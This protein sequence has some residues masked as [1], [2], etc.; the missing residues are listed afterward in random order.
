VDLFSVYPELRDSRLSVL[1]DR[2][3]RLISISGFV[4][5][6]TAFYL[7][8]SEPRQ[9]GRLSDGASVIGV[10]APQ[11]QPGDSD[12]PHQAVIR[13]IRQSWRAAVELFPAGHSY[14]LD[15]AGVT[16]VL[17]DVAAYMP[18]LFIL[19][20]P[21]LG[22]GEV[23]DALVQA[24]YL[25]PLQQIRSH[26]ASVALLQVERDKLGRFLEP[27]SWSLAQARAEPWIG[28][29]PVRSLPD[30]AYL[31]PVLALRGLRRLLED[32]VL[33]GMAAL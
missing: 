2:T 32:G 20:S 22:G 7:E 8:L 28:I 30:N 15:E 3:L 16:H 5:D 24:V 25:F 9:W 12:P 10:R 19:T 33:P 11:V 17:P 31:R 27:E 4:Y 21:R 6:E 1:A 26:L 29:A 23:P 13:Y 14:V 18:Y